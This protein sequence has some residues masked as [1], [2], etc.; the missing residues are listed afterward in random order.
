VVD[1]RLVEDGRRAVGVVAGELHGQLED[2]VGVGCVDWA[3]D[4]GS[5]HGHVFV[6]GKGGYAR[7]GLGHNVHEL[8]LETERAS[9]GERGVRSGLAGYGT[10]DRWATF[11]FAILCG[12]TIALGRK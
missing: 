9:V 3:V 7:C 1:G 6:V 8:L 4:G 2:E 5:P 11:A 10:T 12:V